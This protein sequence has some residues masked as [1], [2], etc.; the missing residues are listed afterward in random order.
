MKN[1]NQKLKEIKKVLN[2]RNR[3]NKHFYAILAIEISILIILLILYFYT[4]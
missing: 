1:Y 2:I 3:I 4:K